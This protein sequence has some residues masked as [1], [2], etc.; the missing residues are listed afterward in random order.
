MI[1][2]ADT[3]AVEFVRGIEQ[4]FLDADIIALRLRGLKAQVE[5]ETI[6][7]ISKMLDETLIKPEHGIGGGDK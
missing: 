5:T 2:W 4:G 3:L 1:D 6:E 7:R